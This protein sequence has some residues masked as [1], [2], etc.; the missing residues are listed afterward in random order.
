[1]TTRSY[2]GLSQI[3]GFK[4]RYDYL[5]LRGSV[6]RATFAYDR[7]INQKF[8]ASREWKDVRHHVIIRDDGCDL[9]VEGFNIVDKIIIHHMNPIVVEDINS[10]SSLIL[11]PEYLICTTSKTHNAIHF[12]D[13]SQLL[14]LPKARTPGDTKLW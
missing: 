6:G 13:E 12:G 8:Y 14:V 4:A 1:M 3:D 2:S 10:R 9:G 7:F 5:R 11:D